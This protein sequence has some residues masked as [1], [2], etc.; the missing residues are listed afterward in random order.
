[1]METDVKIKDFAEAILLAAQKQAL[2]KVV[3]SKSKDKSIIKTVLTLKS[4]SGKLTL[5]A[6]SFHSDNKAKHENIPLDE[7]V[8]ERLC[9]LVDSSLQVNLLTTAG[10]AEYKASRSGKI[11]LIG[12]NN[13]VQKLN[14]DNSEKAQIGGNNHEKNYLISGSAPFLQYL[15][16]SDKN[17]RIY[18][19]K[20]SK[21]RQINKFV[22]NVRDI[23]PHLPKE[24]ELVVYDLCC[25]KSYL[26]FAVYH[27]LKNVCGREVVMYGVD[28]KA[29][30]IEY[31]NKV[32]R[33]VGFDTLKFFC[34]DITKYECQKKPDLVISLHACDIATDIVLDKAIKE[35]AKVIL[36]TPCCHHELNH[37]I[38]CKELSFVT[39]YSMLRQ[40]L[41]DAATDALR[42][43]RL[44]ANNYACVAVELIDPEETPKNI[45]L[46]A[47][48]KPS[49]PINLKKADAA[50]L[51]YE[52]ARKF[53]LGL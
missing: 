31:C 52:A 50:A 11:T 30:V 12:L 4:I 43:K 20:Q 14:A 49:T 6:E 24:G 21:F 3:F 18:D 36:S 9:S 2:K 42:L 37:T 32:A 22:E 26:S 7:N 28:L 46:R 19:K 25:G 27:Y 10:D 51:E 48:K 41:C 39:D 8:A 16:V 17:G 47:I 1:M 38:N 45:L 13:L 44:E 15:G 40:K 53:L 35:E 23:Y 34:E 29:D 33:E 5:Q